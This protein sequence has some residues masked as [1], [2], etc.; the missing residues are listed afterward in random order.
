MAV[1]IEQPNAPRS[2]KG[3]QWEKR[4][5][6]FMRVSGIILVGMIIGHL[7][8]NLVLPERGVK[9]IDFAFVAG[10]WASPFWQVYD[11]ILLCTLV[12]TTFDPCIDPNVHEY[13]PELVC[14]G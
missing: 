10:K 4:A 3:A 1:I 13:L 14:K 7:M 8:V 12:I 9:S 5:W 11:G 2:R 6:I